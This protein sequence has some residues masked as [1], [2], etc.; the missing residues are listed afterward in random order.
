MQL[1]V[2]D[3]FKKPY[4]IWK[5][6][7]AT[8]EESI[9]NFSAYGYFIDKVPDKLIKKISNAYEAAVHMA[10]VGADSALE[11]H[12]D[13]ELDANDSF[14]V[15]RRSMPSKT[16]NQ[17]TNYQRQH[18]LNESISKVIKEIDCILTEG[19]F[20]FHG[21]CWWGGS[22]GSECTTSSPL[23]T[24]FCPQVALRNAEWAG[25]AYDAGVI[26]L[27]VLQ[28]TNPVTRVFSYKIKGT[29]KGH[30]K[31]VLFSSGAKLKLIHSEVVRSD[32]RVCKVI[33]G[34]ARC[35]EKDVL[36]NVKLVEIS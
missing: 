9:Q 2:I 25:K 16:P 5:Y 19:Q 7:D 35:D 21:G 32:Y 36:I 30:E 34:S 27:L 15:W 1:P 33:S 13:D 29:N 20:L 28:V 6:R 17:L 23:S 24:S 10:L 8:Q 12:I 14:R 31:E 4:E 26:D 3:V 11:K 22:I 18:I